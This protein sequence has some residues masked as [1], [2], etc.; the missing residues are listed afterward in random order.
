MKKFLPHIILII[1]VVVLSCVSFA[2][3]NY[4]Q[5]RV[6][7]EVYKDG[8]LIKTIDLNGVDND[9]EF[10][11]G[12]ENEYNIVRVE[13]GRIR[14]MSASCP[15]KICVNQGYIS[16]GLVPI[17]CLPNKVVIKIKG[18]EDEADASVG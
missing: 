6:A 17:V 3:Y 9:Y 8:E 13:N 4:K 18:G 10:T 5:T 7:A 2:V 1:L 15:D 11:V 12:D 14:V 16:D